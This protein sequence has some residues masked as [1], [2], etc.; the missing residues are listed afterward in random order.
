M[1]KYES[2]KKY[3]VIKEGARLSGM[4]PTAPYCQTGWRQDLHVGDVLTCA[5]RSMTS[6][7]GVPALKWKDADGEWLANDCL[8]HPVQGGM[9][10]G[11]VPV[12]GYLEEAV[13]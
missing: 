2:G 8:F 13:K 11:Q 7:D 9:W 6:G 1:S 5:G 3:R 10:S 12:D 4:K